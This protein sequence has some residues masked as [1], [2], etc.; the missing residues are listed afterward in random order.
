MQGLEFIFVTVIGACIGGLLRYLL[1][2]RA[3]Y[4]LLLVP[5]IGAAATAVVWVA[6]LWLGLT[7][8]GGWI[9]FLALLAGGLAS[10]ATAI[11]LPRVRPA[12]DERRIAELTAT[13]A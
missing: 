2:G 3:T 6:L 11:I 9:W 8:D 1:P 12:R 5:A 10:L 7:F 4:G 13:R